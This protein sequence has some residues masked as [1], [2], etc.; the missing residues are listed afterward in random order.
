M[1]TGQ[2]YTLIYVFNT[3]PTYFPHLPTHT[4]L[5]YTTGFKSRIP[6]PVIVRQGIYMYVH[7]V[8]AISL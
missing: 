7:I 3:T 4:Q 1:N 2:H 6:S 5:A 8:A